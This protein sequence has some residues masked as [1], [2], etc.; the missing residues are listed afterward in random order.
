MEPQ[1]LALEKQPYTP[2]TFSA[3]GHVRDFVKNGSTNGTGD[4]D[5]DDKI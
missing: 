1:P 2:P 3:L 4:I 5:Y